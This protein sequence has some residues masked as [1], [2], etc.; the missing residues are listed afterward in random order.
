MTL[1][2]FNLGWST[3]SLSVSFNGNSAAFKR[4]EIMGILDSNFREYVLT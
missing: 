4:L 1:V 2:H 3:L